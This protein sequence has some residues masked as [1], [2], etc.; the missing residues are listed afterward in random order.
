V[1]GKSVFL[2]QMSKFIEWLQNAE[3]GNLVK[4]WKFAIEIFVK[5]FLFLSIF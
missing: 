4:N 2:E 3:E 1:K 5:M